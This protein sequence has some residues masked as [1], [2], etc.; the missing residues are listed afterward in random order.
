MKSVIFDQMEQ[1]LTKAFSM[2]F[3]D[4]QKKGVNVKKLHW[5]LSE[6]EKDKINADK[7]K[8]A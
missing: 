6:K 3:A 5:F 4:A 7:S 2:A 8:V 1:A